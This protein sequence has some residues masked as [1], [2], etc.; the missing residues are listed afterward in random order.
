MH[1]ELLV[2]ESKRHSRRQQQLEEREAEKKIEIVVGPLNKI[3][4]GRGIRPSEPTRSHASVNGLLVSRPD[5]TGPVHKCATD[6]IRVG[7]A[8]RAGS[9]RTMNRPS[10]SK[11]L[12]A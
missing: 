6:C 2:E 3:S 7:L 4:C 8:V 10:V 5:R 1:A 11:L 9:D 12:L